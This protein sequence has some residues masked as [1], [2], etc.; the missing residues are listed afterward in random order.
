M[1]PK[2]N[3]QWN[4][5][6]GSVCPDGKLQTP[7]VLK[8][9]A[10][11][12]LE[13][14]FALLVYFLDANTATLPDVVSIIA[15]ALY[16]KQTRTTL[17]TKYCVNYDQ[18]LRLI[19][20][21]LRSWLKHSDPSKISYN[22]IQREFFFMSSWYFIMFSSTAHLFILYMFAVA[23]IFFLQ[24]NLVLISLTTSLPT[25]PLLKE[26]RIFSFSKSDVLF[27]KFREFQVI[28]FV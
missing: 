20:Y 27:S 13:F 7:P 17:Y 15:D 4:L 26:R 12:E 21:L 6:I 11:E 9:P 10:N 18:W 16:N 28:W 23:L 1:Y 19:Y 14:G 22:I 24:L 5:P 3:F 8:L 2:T 25:S